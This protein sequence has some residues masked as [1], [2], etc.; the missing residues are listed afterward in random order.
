LAAEFDRTHRLLRPRAGKLRRPPRHA[1]HLR[2]CVCV[3][4]CQHVGQQDRWLGCWSATHASDSVDLSQH[5]DGDFEGRREANAWRSQQF[6]MPQL[7]H[8]LVEKTSEVAEN[9]PPRAPGQERDVR[10]RCETAI[11]LPLV[12]CPSR[13][14]RCCCPSFCRPAAPA[15][16]PCGLALGTRHGVAR[17]L[18]AAR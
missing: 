10:R 13:R 9:E 5:G 7:S 12:H 16:K 2:S 17:E 14:R 3:C 4:V 15:C 6:I 11:A 8:N 18:P 1:C